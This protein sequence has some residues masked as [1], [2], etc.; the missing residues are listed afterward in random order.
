MPQLEQSGRP[1]EVD[2]SISS[3]GGG[4]LEK[5]TRFRR[6]RETALDLQEQVD[7]IQE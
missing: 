4:L 3:H 1:F 7:K 5:L 2:C 6:L